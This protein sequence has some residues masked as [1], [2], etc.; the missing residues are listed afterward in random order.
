MARR[1]G[2]W[3]RGPV[4]R[5]AAFAVLC[6]LSLGAC[7]DEQPTD[8]LD[9]DV[10][11]ALAEAG[12]DARGEALTG[13]YFTRAEVR[14]CDCPRRMGVDLCGPAAAQLIGLDG[15]AAVTQ[16]DGWLTFEPEAASLPWALSGAAWRDRSFTL[17]AIS[18]LA[19]GLF[20]VG[21]HARFEGEFAADRSLQ[22]ELAHRLVGE[23]PD[24]AVDCRTT[25]AITG[26]AAPDA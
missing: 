16:V 22:G 10:L 1:A 21:L 9:P 24:G 15:P 20:S 13:R 2:R 6:A 7:P 12:G 23:L 18:G 26:W 17:A 19:I 11:A 8:P 5:R 3:Y 4:L 25:Y 14:A